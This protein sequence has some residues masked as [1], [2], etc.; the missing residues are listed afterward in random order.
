MTRSCK[1]PMVWPRYSVGYFYQPDMS[2]D[3]AQVAKMEMIGKK[4][5]LKP[6]DI[7]T[8]ERDSGA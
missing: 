2:L 3:E 6:G 8:R 7:T 1:S 4:L 5:A